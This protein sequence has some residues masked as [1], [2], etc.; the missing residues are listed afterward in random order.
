VLLL[1]LLLLLAA[2]LRA[3]VCGVNYRPAQLMHHLH[4]RRTRLV[5]QRC[6]CRTWAALCFW[7]TVTPI[8]LHVACSRDVQ[9]LEWKL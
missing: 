8:S 4:C 7:R 5:Q 9:R 6:V 3:A 2:S 1:L